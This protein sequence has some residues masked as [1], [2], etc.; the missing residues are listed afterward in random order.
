M[1]TILRD[2]VIRDYV[3]FRIGEHFVKGWNHKHKITGKT[4][5]VF[6]H[7]HPGEDGGWAMYYDIKKGKC[8]GCK[9]KFAPHNS[10]VLA[11]RLH[12][13]NNSGAG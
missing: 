3:E 9:K 4:F 1:G 7:C 6:K 11:A 13:F 2:A 5:W 8:K 12:L 10:L